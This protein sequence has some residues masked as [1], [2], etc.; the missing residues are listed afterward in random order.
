MAEKK[1][2]KK[3]EEEEGESMAM[4]KMQVFY[5]LS[6]N[7]QLEQPHFVELNLPANRPLRLRDVMDRLA[8]L[9]GKAMPALYSW[10][11]K[12]SYKCGYVWNDLSEN[13]VVYPADAVGAEYVLKGSQLLHHSSELVTE[14]APSRS[15]VL[16]QFIACGS[17]SVSKGKTGPGPIEPAKEIGRRTESL[18]KGV[19][20]KIA[21]KLHVGGDEEMINYMSE[22]PRFGNLQ[23]EEKEYFSGSI[24]ESIREDRHVAEPA[25]KKS[26]SYNEEKSK[27]GE[28]GDKRDEEEQRAQEEDG[29]GKGRC[30]PRMISASASSSKQPTRP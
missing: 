6:R 13:D 18:R 22:N 30:L 15:S 12:R 17:S 19:A 16:L 11:C 20:C 3:E 14:S 7:G 8:V 5:Y 9:R 29:C 21:G 28:F 25:L 27:R 23:S 26:N 24:V 1:K 4:K 2:T 10:S